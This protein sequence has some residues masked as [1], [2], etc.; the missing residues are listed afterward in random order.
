MAKMM[1]IKT[2]IMMMTTMMMITLLCPSPTVWQSCSVSR[3]PWSSPRCGCRSP[4][5]G[6]AASFAPWHWTGLCLVQKVKKNLRYSSNKILTAKLS[7][8][9]SPKVCDQCIPEYFQ[10]FHLLFC[11]RCW[12]LRWSGLNLLV[13]SLKYYDHGS[14]YGYDAKCVME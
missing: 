14:D 5:T 7:K 13:M 6:A 9:G 3:T 2:A 4:S 10:L 11:R 8:A 12:A 1:M